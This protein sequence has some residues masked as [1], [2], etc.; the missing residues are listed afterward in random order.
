MD[1]ALSEEERLL[2][3]EIRRFCLKEVRPRAIAVDRDPNHRFD[4]DIIKT[5]AEFGYLGLP[6]PEEYG[7][8]GA[9][10]FAPALA[11][12]ELA[13]ADAGIATSVGVS[14]AL[15]LMILLEGN[16]KHMKEYLPMLAS[17]EGNLG[18]MATTEPGGGS[19]QLSVERFRP[20]YTQTTATRDGDEYVLNGTKQFCSNAGLAKLYLVS[21]TMDR[22]AGPEATLQLLVPAD[23][24]GL[25]VGAPEDKMGQRAGQTASLI[26]EDVRVPAENLYGEEGKGVEYNEKRLMPLS[27]PS[28]GLLAVGIARAAYDEALAFARERIQGGRPIIEHQAVALLLADM[29]VQIEAGRALAYY[30][31]WKNI[32]TIGGAPEL[33]SMAKVFCSDLAMK[34]TTDAVQIL[35]GYGYMKDYLV[36]KLMRDAKITQIYEG[37]NQICR[38]DVMNYSQQRITSNRSSEGGI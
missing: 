31:I 8:A 26:F 21:A 16:P 6:V 25:S 9:S 34:V 5:M 19:D 3:Q 18:A 22:K 11:I 24:R 10:L 37:T 20:G 27:R 15:Q 32:Q 30:A 12:E 4:W 35:G 33:S 28:V 36:E 7:G 29:A 1:F 38:L 23:A 13:Y 2:Q 14:W 17:K